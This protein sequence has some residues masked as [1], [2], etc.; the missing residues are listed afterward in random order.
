MFLRGLIFYLPLHRPVT[1]ASEIL[2]LR[3][4]AP[5]LERLGPAWLHRWVMEKMPVRNVRR[6]VQITDALY[7]RSLEIFRTKKAAL[8][9]GEDTD[10][11]DIMSI[12]RT[13]RCS[14]CIF[15]SHHL[16]TVRAN[17]EA[18]GEDQLPEDQLLGQMSYAFP[19]TSTRSRMSM[20]PIS[21]LSSSPP[22]TLHRTPCRARCSSLQ[23][24]RRCKQNCGARSLMRSSLPADP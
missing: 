6:A 12:L 10:A 23:S 22:W 4:L 24:T 18:S 14:L 13:S 15:P 2:L 9:A 20:T 21:G 16:C 1:T 11:K 8:E 17:M 3:Q 19:Q 7:E 5:F